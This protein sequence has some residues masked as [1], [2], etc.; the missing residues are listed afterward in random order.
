M[1]LPGPVLPRLSR[2]S[3]PPRSS[4]L[5]A[6]T[7]VLVAG[8]LLALSGCTGGMVQIEAAPNARAPEC[9]PVMLSLPE[10]IEGQSAR[11]TSA[12]A[13]EA[14]GDPS[15]AVLRCGM[16]PP[17]PTTDPCVTVN[18]VDWISTAA[19]D[20]HWKFV[21]YGREPA[22][23]VI[24]DPTAVGGQNI[25]AEISP[26]VASLPQTGGCVSAEDATQVEEAVPSS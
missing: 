10:E 25:L 11:D 13:T 19:E 4:G 20:D 21:T 6:R 24:V 14:W 22:V 2:V 23:E 9:A 3:R 12:Q 1:R 8:G 7:A 17:A 16:E 18:G 5:T 15:I 26:A